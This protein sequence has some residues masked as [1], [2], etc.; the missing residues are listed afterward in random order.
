MLS[1]SPNK[2]GSSVG[3][4]EVT[5]EGVVTTGTVTVGK[6]GSGRVGEQ[7]AKDTGQGG[8]SGILQEQGI[9]RGG[10]G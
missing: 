3:S 6:E 7:G 5:V 9:Q 8:Q 2:A 4:G 10:G 1:D